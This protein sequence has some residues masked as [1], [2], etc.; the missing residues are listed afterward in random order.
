MLKPE[1]RENLKSV[2]QALALNNSVKKSKRHTNKVKEGTKKKAEISEI[3][4]K[5][6]REK[7]WKKLVIWNDQ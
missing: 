6:N 4:T 1:K 3:E 5:N 2:R 7:Q